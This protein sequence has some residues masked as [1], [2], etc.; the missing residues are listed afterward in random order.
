[1]NMI[2]LQIE[3][4][5][6][7]EKN[8]LLED[9]FSILKGVKMHKIL[10]YVGFG[11]YMY[12]FMFMFLL[13]FWVPIAGFLNFKNFAFNP[14]MSEEINKNE[15]EASFLLAICSIIIIVYFVYIWRIING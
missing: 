11:I 6:Q 2:L 10:E 7:V 15:K 13:I 5:L 8:L 12:F 14:K 4:N 3:K 1:M 9:F